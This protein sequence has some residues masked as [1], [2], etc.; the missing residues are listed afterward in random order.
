MNNV[1]AI[2]KLQE[3]LIS[4]TANW[5]GYQKLSEEKIRDID[6]EISS[7]AKEGLLD[8][9]KTMTTERDDWVRSEKFAQVIRKNVRNIGDCI[10]WKLLGYNRAWIGVLG[11]KEPIGKIEMNVSLENELSNLYSEMMME[12]NL[13]LLN[14]LTNVIRTGDITIKTKD[15]KYRLR[16]IKSSENKD[17][18][19]RKQENHRKRI[20]EFFSTGRLEDEK[21]VWEIEPIKTPIKTYF[22][23]ILEILINADKDGIASGYLEEFLKVDAMFLRKIPRDSAESFFQEKLLPR[24]PSWSDND[25]TLTLDSTGGLKLDLKHH[26]PPG[27]FPLP[28]DYCAK[29]TTGQLVIISTLNLNLLAKHLEKSGWMVEMLSKKEDILHHTFNLR[30]GKLT[31]TFS[32]KLIGCLALQF[33]HIDTIINM[34]DETYD[35]GFK[36]PKVKYLFHFE[37]EKTAYA[38]ANTLAVAKFVSYPLQPNTTRRG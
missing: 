29:L 26:V 34:F 20:V 28:I 36:S 25:R 16:E 9:I 11:D 24:L 37:N 8:K 23:D 31:T 14:D 4:D 27:L 1:Y 7:F 35:A 30:R 5:Q 6:N 32:T 2:Y 33:M 18:R 3:N 22:D 12:G 19:T 10:A 17:K 13:A 38:Y 21:G 15:N